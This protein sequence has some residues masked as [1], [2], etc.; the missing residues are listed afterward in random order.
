MY[1]KRI[2]RFIRRKSP[3]QIRVLLEAQRE[4]QLKKAAP[5]ITKD[6][7]VKD[8]EK[9]GLQKGD[10]AFLHSSLKSIGYVAGGA[11][12]VIDAITEVLGSSG[13]FIVPTYSMKKSMYKGM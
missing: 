7:I 3:K 1:K 8:L 9:L 12:T 5:R 4:K 6:I 13:T 10:A 2:K 11:R